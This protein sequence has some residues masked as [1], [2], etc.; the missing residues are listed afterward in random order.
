MTLKT[1]FIFLVTFTLSALGLHGIS[2]FLEQNQAQLE[3]KQ[4]QIILEDIKFRF[5]MFLDLQTSI[6]AIGSE[7]FSTGKLES[8]PYYPLD[9][10]LLQINKQL[11][12]LNLVNKDG[13][14]VRVYPENANKRALGLVSQNYEALKNSYAKGEP[15]WLSPPVSLFQGEPGFAMYFPIVHEAQLKGWFATVVTT[16]IFRKDFGL[17]NFLNSYHLV[18]QDKET[19]GQFY[20]TGVLPENES[21]VNKTTSHFYNREL[22]FISWRKDPT[23]III[24]PRSLIGLGSFF[25]SLLVMLILHFYNQK[26]RARNQLEDISMLLNLTSKEALSK[27]IDLQNEIYKIGNTENALYITNLIEQID[28]LKSTASSKQ[29]LEQV[30]VNVLSVLKSELDEMRDLLEKKGIKL[31]FIPEKF[32]NVLTETNQWLFKNTVIGSILTYAIVHS[33]NGSALTIEYQNYHSMHV[34][35]I[36]TQRVYKFDAEG[37]SINLERRIDVAKKVLSISGGDLQTDQ[38]LAGG[39]IMRI[40]LPVAN[41]R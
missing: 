34:I 28:L 41:Q 2:V 33:D 35:T 23:A 16:E 1:I 22:N 6:G 18:I 21:E 7:H 5:K 14:I 38:D 25:I 36:H 24:L 31:H 37:H 39:M 27:L 30:T 9:E 3:R 12:G 20:A 13:I 19:Q 17:Q 40:Q 32:L 29:E 10:K 11:Y 15:F 4:N 26:K 8:K